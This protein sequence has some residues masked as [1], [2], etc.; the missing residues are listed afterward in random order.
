MLL[1]GAR[2]IQEYYPIYRDPQTLLYSRWESAADRHDKV[3]SF[4]LAS[5]A[6]Q[7]LP[8]NLA[9]VEDADAF[10]VN[11]GLIGFSSTRRGG[12]YD[13]FF[14]NPSTGAAYAVGQSSDALHELAGC[15]SPHSSARALSLVSPG[16]DVQRAAGSAMVVKAKGYANG[17]VWL[18]AAPHLVLEGPAVVEVVLHDDGSGVDGG[19]DDGIYSAV[20]TLPSQPGTYQAYASAI[21]TDNGLT[22]ELRS[23]SSAV[24]LTEAAPTAVVQIGAERAARFQLGPSAPNPSRRLASIEF[25]IPKPGFTSLEIFDALGVRVE[26]LVERDLPAGRFRAR[27][28]GSWLPSGAYFYRLRAGEFVDTR[29]VVLVK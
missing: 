14:G 29:K 27:W 6:T 11:E 10:P 13:L 20:V 21:S 3:Y 9:G 19:A 24:T 28:D 7:R 22:R 23:S 18:R 25:A 17:G 5:G 12:G 15:Y 4:S 26:T 1:V 8:L 2:E 16:T